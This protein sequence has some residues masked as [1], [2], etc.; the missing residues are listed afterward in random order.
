MPYVVCPQC[1][2]QNR[3]PIEKEGLQGKCG[4]CGLLLPSFSLHRP[5]EL[6]DGDFDLFVKQYRDLLCLVDF[7][8]PSCGPCQMLA[9]IIDALPGK[10]KGKLAV[11]KLNTGTNPRIATRFRISGV[12]TLL[13]F[14]NGQL[15]DQA[16]G[17]LPEYALSQRVHN[18]L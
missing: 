6:R 5:V 1:R 16:V 7:Y 4:R 15:V 8:S 18:L 9:P 10:F 13:F 17:A 3:I 12:P 11:G 2:T 14:K